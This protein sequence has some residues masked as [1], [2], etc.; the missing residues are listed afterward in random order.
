MISQEYVDHLEEQNAALIEEVTKLREENTKLRGDNAE[1]AMEDDDA[2][3]W[4][5]GEPVEPKPLEDLIPTM[6]EADVEKLKDN[7]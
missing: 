6:S 5:D 1:A 3:S 2:E 7:S 4:A